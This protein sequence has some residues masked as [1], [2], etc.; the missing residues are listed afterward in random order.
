MTR[1]PVAPDSSTLSS[2]VTD[3]PE[4]HARSIERL[5]REHNDSLLQF[6]SA[7]LGSHQEAKEIAQEAYVR[8]LKLDTPGAVSYLRAFLFKTASNLAVDRLRTRSYRE[9]PTSLEFFER[10]PDATTPERDVSGRQEMQLLLR[11]IEQ[12]PPRARYAF[13]Q[14]KFYGLDVETIAK[15][16]GITKRMVRVHIVRA[17]IHCRTG[18][19]SATGLNRKEGDHAR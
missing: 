5:F 16:M 9:R 8:L 15:D 11:L 7:R 1:K 6:L 2:P 14:N 17:L 18:L 10:L 4:N 13:I 19:D 12:L 3:A